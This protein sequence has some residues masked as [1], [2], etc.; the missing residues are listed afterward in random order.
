M[1]TIKQMRQKPIKL[2][3]VFYTA[4]SLIWIFATA[5]NVQV[6]PVIARNTWRT[7]S[8]FPSNNCGRHCCDVKER[9]I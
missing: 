8:I 5:L 1:T 9:W 3:A 6:L 2:K 4:L 7:I